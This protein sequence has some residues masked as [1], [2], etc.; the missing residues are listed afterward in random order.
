MQ[1]CKDNVVQNK[2]RNA[3][4]FA[5]YPKCIHWRLEF[6][7]LENIKHINIDFFDIWLYI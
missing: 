7:I 2:N 4:I 3:N 5:W 1:K 6:S